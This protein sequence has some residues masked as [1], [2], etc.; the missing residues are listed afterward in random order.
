LT[1]QSSIIQTVRLILVKVL[2]FL[3]INNNIVKITLF[4]NNCGRSV[5]FQLKQTTVF[6][7]SEQIYKINYIELRVNRLEAPRA[8]FD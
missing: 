4:C 2:Y 1:L 5:C 6:K 3:M 7:Y 8:P